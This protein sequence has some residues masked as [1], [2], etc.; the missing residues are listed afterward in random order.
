MPVREGL[1]S[2]PCT[3]KVNDRTVLN[4]K[5]DLMLCPPREAGRHRL[6][7]RSESHPTPR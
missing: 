1:P 5:G 6:C 2:G 7:G 4:G 3:K